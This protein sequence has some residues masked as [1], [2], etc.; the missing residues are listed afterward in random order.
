MKRILI[1]GYYSLNNLG[2]ELFKPSFKK[3]F[4]HAELTFQN[5]DHIHSIHDNSYDAVFLGAGEVLNEYFLSKLKHINIPFV[6]FG[7]GFAGTDINLDSLW[8]FDAIAVRHRDMHILDQLNSRFEPCNFISIPYIVF[9]L[10]KPQILHSSQS[11]QIAFIP[12]SDRIQ[13]KEYTDLLN[14]FPQCY[15]MILDSNLDKHFIGEYID[16]LD[17]FQTHYKFI[18]TY[19]FHGIVLGIMT[20]KL[21]ICDNLI[22]KNRELM[23]TIFEDLAPCL[24]FNS[25]S[26]SLNADIRRCIKAALIHKHTLRKRIQQYLDYTQCF[27]NTWNGED[28]LDELLIK[29]REYKS[30]PSVIV[31][32]L[33]NQSVK[34]IQSHFKLSNNSIYRWGLENNNKYSKT[35]QLEWLQSDVHK[36][37]LK[38]RPFYM[39]ITPHIFSDNTH[40]YGWNYVTDLLQCLISKH[41]MLLDSFLDHSFDARPYLVPFIGIIHHP[42]NINKHYSNFFYLSKPFCRQLLVLTNYLKTQLAEYFPCN[43]ITV[44]YHPMYACTHQWSFDAWKHLRRC[45]AIG[46]WLRNTF[47]IYLL[48]YSNKYAIKSHHG[49]PPNKIYAYKLKNNQSTCNAEQESCNGSGGNIDKNN[50]LYFANMYFNKLG[51]NLSLTQHKNQHRQFIIEELIVCIIKSV[52]LIDWIDAHEYDNMLTSSVILLDLFDCSASNT[53]LECIM[54][55]TPVY[56]RRLPAVEEYI[57]TEYPLFFNNVDDIFINDNDILQAHHYLQK[58]DKFKFSSDHFIQSMKNLKV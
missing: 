37:I 51:F 27:F 43:K 22:Y 38:A 19:K 44:I 24:M 9:S 32:K 55:N 20:H 46:G 39:N 4:P 42:G 21:V 57:G 16:S 23:H 14:E 7:V 12:S 2:D 13:I 49:Q 6:A 15:S 54:T 50:W 5:I 11:S 29:R 10:Y 25:K 31:D 35:K 1:I 41:G 52:H 56:V 8:Q 48:N 40:R 36:N 58:L 47:S 26:H 17:K 30:N 45:F 33:A 28:Y 3:L 53:L 18:V 34:N